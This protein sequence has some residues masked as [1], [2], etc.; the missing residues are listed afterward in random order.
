MHA[1][2]GRKKRNL[3]RKRRSIPIRH[4]ETTRLG[5]LVLVGEEVREYCGE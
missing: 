1:G 4:N 5:L 3:V 2:K